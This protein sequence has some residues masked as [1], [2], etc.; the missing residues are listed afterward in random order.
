MQTKLG[1]GIAL[2]MGLA[3]WVATGVGV[4]AQE[5][6]GTIDSHRSSLRERC[7]EL[8]PHE[9][10]SQEA[11]SR[12]ETRRSSAVTSAPTHRS[13]PLQHERRGA[14]AVTAAANMTKVGRSVDNAAW[15]EAAQFGVIALL[16][17]LPRGDA[18]TPSPWARALTAGESADLTVRDPMHDAA[19]DTSFRVA[20]SPR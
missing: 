17:A 8:V 16:A 5:S 7:E 4:A 19:I 11:A 1:M 9:T 6:A 10:V 15:Q 13:E 2:A 18:N 12:S 20:L 3:A 14:Q